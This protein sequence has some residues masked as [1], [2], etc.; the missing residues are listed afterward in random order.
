MNR[1]III[2]I[3]AITLVGLIFILT[4]QHYLQRNNTDIKTSIPIYKN[5]PVPKG[6]SKVETDGASWN[7]KDG[8]IDGWNN[9]LVIEDSDGNQFV[10]VPCSVEESNEVVLYSR[11]YDY[12]KPNNTIPAKDDKIYHTT[13][14]Y[15]YE[16]DSINEDIKNSIVKYGGFYIGRYEAGIEN[17]KVCVK[18]DVDAYT[19]VTQNDAIELSKSL[20]SDNNIRSYLMTSY[21]Y[22]TTIKWMSKSDNNFYNDKSKRFE[23][24]DGEISINQISQKT[25][26]KSEFDINNINNLFGN[27]IEWTT[28]KYSDQN[29]KILGVC[30]RNIGSRG[31]IEQAKAYMDFMDYTI[32]VRSIMRQ[33]YSDQIHGFRVVLVID[34]I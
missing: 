9:G 11:Y 20:K 34:S 8:I 29:G 31:H 33:N 23:Y 24:M 25:G 3:I 10:W 32:N 6:F 18:S 16:D 13:K 28:E 2:A 4:M 17:N 27:I 21:C 5:P 30:R 1:R 19:N 15:F 12:G 14:N 26:G 7:E 22:D